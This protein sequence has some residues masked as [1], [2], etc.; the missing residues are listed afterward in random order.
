[1]DGKI[2]TNLE[3]MELLCDVGTA[4]LPSPQSQEENCNNVSD[5]TDTFCDEPLLRN[6][7][8]FNLSPMYITHYNLFMLHIRIINILLW[9]QRHILSNLLYNSSRCH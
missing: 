9:A 6:V 7:T 8:N 3:D 1:M 4:R 2:R 5:T